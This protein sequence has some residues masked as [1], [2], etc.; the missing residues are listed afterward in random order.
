[1]SAEQGKILDPA[2]MRKLER[3]ELIAR[4]VQAG[5]VKGERRS[6]RRGVSIEFADYRDYVQGDDMRH[7]DW[8]IFGRLDSFHLKL[9]EDHEDLTLHIIVDA[10]RSMAFGAPG[11]LEYA[12]KLAAAIGYIGLAGHDRVC[13][14]A[15][16]GEGSALFP[17]ARGKGSAGELFKFL[18]S[19]RPGG[20]TE[21]ESAIKAHFL[22]VRNKGVAVVISDF[23][24]EGGYEDALR[25]LAMCGSEM[26]AIQVLAPE[27][28]DPGVSGDI[29]LVDSEGGDA[30]EITVTPAMLK[31]YH[32]RREEFCEGLRR[33]CL[34]RG[35][36][37]FLAASDTPVERLTL[38]LLRKG[39]MIK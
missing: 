18:N 17:P 34:A 36:G 26:Y 16:S 22:K 8:N 12:C 9:F 11:K 38:D 15:F 5:A 4:R 1:M 39:G 20:S 6:P 24:V 37:Y 28:M 27:E 10:S 19:I 30:V 2:F 3:L 33:F 14:E 29:K 23:F 32:Q 31:R 7:I 35:M 21:L 25:R 13:V